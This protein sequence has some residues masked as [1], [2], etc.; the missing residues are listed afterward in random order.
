MEIRKQCHE[1]S[2]Y[3]KLWGSRRLVKVKDLTF[4]DLP[5]LDL[6]MKC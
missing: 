4:G 1:L 2:V 6:K 5:F 3:Y